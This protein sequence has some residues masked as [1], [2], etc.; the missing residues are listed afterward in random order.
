MTQFR[1]IY[2]CPCGTHWT[3]DWDCMCDDRCPSC[4]T[5]CSPTSSV[6]LIGESPVLTFAKDF[7][8]IEAMM[9]KIFETYGQS[10]KSNQ[11]TLTGRMV[12][13]NMPWK[14][15]FE[16][17]EMRKPILSGPS[18]LPSI[19]NAAKSQLFHELY[20]FSGRMVII[21][22]MINFPMLPEH[23]EGIPYDPMDFYEDGDRLIYGT[24][25]F[26]LTEKDWERTRFVAGGETPPDAKKRAKL[27]AKR[28]K[29]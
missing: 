5:S 6:E 22:D 7:N 1:N 24:F 23:E 27:K 10:Q 28:K 16:E 11:G 3:D 20:G 8:K 14:E 18:M 2:D 13:R 9:A 26:P 29:R 4:N 17:Y 25:R 15:A 21:D 12:S 19:R